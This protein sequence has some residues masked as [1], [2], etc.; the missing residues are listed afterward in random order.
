MAMR[1]FKV[2]SSA[3]VISLLSGCVA[4]E[5]HYYLNKDGN[6]KVRLSA[7]FQ[8]MDLQRKTQQERTD[9]APDRD[10]TLEMLENARKVIKNAEGVEAWDSIQYGLTSGG[11][12][13]FKGVAYF[14]D[15][16]N[17]MFE[18]IPVLPVK[19]FTENKIIWGLEP[20]DVDTAKP[21]PYRDSPLSK[22]AVQDRVK[23]LQ[24]Q[25]KRESKMMKMVMTLFEYK[26]IYH[27]PYDIKDVK[28]VEKV[29][30]R[31]V[32]VSL[33]LDRWMKAFDQ[34]MENEE[35]LRELV[36][37]KGVNRF[38]LDNKHLLKAAYKGKALKKVTFRTGL[39][40]KSPKDN[41]A[42][43]ETVQVIEPKKPDIPK[44]EGYE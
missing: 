3:V 9:E 25:Y 24:R 12:T 30:E 8:K 15:I 10:D 23:S 27:L 6:G 41:F 42:Y 13:T 4:T 18:K 28:G 1:L 26:A 21:R 32:K 14:R 5:Q 34:L 16:T 38:S 33:D 40:A 39:F 11:E 37:K 17:L 31:K 22:A 19:K 20:E 7:T 2:I 29:D 35:K 43:E 36:A 44:P